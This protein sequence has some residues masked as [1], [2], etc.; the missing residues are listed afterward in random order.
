MKN[1]FEINENNAKLY[2][3][4]KPLYKTKNGELFSIKYDLDSS[5][6]KNIFILK[7]IEVKTEEEKN[8]LLEEAKSLNDINSKYIFKIY[9]Y[10]F[11]NL[12]EQEYF[13]IITDYFD[14]NNNIKNKI[15]K[16]YFN[17]R[18]VWRFFVEMVLGLKSLNEQHI[19]I[20]NFLPQNIFI[21]KNNDYKITGI[22]KILDMNKEDENMD[23]IWMYESPELL[24]G[25]K[26]DDLSSIWS[27]GTILYEIA[28]KNN[29]FNSK[30]NIL[31]V[32]YV[33]P[34]ES[35][36]DLKSVLKKLL[37]RKTYRKPIKELIFDPIFKK[38]I[39]E[40]NLFYDNINLD[41]NSKS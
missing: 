29:A 31:N 22:G 1:K 24:N 30:E 40:E 7:R 19:L 27:L 9:S 4:L 11:E 3:I 38:K 2:S 8:K 16:N 37:C 26:L 36:N 23:N 12:N 10:F 17:S 6:E 35:E 34:E 33:I 41:M 14:N 25:E 5:K 18:N 20:S 15:V 21:D 13:C 39:I 32:N 28:F